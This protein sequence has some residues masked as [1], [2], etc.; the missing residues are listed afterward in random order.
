[1]DDLTHK[2]AQIPP[3][4]WMKYTWFAILMFSS[5]NLILCYTIAFD[6]GIVVASPF[7][8]SLVV[9][10]T[11]SAIAV[12]IGSKI[13]FH[14]TE[15]MIAGAVVAFCFYMGIISF[16]MFVAS[17]DLISTTPSTKCRPLFQFVSFLL[18]VLFVAFSVITGKNMELIIDPR[19][20]P[21]VTRDAMG[22]AMDARIS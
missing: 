12:V 21:K 11:V 13:L 18:F 19:N 6:G 17:F 1:M 8:A 9:T 4:N 10:G 3:S 20:L 14:K 15:L 22:N 5:F 7:A 16:I 2:I